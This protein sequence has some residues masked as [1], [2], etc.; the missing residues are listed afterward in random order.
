MKS[1]LLIGFMIRYSEGSF[2]FYA[3]FPILFK[4]KK[5]HC[6]CADKW[7]VFV[8]TKE[9]LRRG[10]QSCMIFFFSVN[11]CELNLKQGVSGLWRILFYIPLFAPLQSP[12][13][14]AVIY[15]EV[16]VSVKM[17]DEMG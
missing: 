14:L 4:K 1:I 2:S 10:R 12:M 11:I 8:V 7:M 17:T 9:E 5:N 16:L 3:H 13:I 15:Q 6:S